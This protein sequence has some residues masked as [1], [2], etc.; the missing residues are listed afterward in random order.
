MSTI[1]DL[2]EKSRTLFGKTRNTRNL[3]H[4]WVLKTFELENRGI[5]LLR[6]G[7][8]PGKVVRVEEVE[9]EVDPNEGLMR[10]IAPNY[11][12]GLAFHFR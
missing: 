10:T 6:T 3:R 9:E 1:K 12:H 2:I 5:H 4:Q 8:F 11:E 7:K